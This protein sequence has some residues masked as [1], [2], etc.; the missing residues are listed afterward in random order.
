MSI[1]SFIIKWTKQQKRERKKRERGERKVLKK[2]TGRVKEIA[3]EEV[4][5]AHY[6]I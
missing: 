4:V 6:K 3:A 2:G 5:S 1:A